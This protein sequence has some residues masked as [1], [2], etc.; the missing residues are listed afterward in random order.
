ML[1]M[2]IEIESNDFSL[3]NIYWSFRLLKFKFDTSKGCVQ[4]IVKVVLAIWLL[5]VLCEF[6]GFRLKQVY[7]QTCWGVDE[8]YWFDNTLIYLNW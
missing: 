2:P 5:D 4:N 8:H 6:D 3:E 1:K 7:V